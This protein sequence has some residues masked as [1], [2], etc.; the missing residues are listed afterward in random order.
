MI[1]KRNENGI[2]MRRTKLKEILSKKLFSD[3][4]FER[5]KN[6]RNK[7]FCNLCKEEK[8]IVIGNINHH[9]I[10]Y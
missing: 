5:K 3:F 8:L 7:P 2:E 1:M 6:D 9:G 4:T 10:Q